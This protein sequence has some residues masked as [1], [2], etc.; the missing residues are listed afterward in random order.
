M[1]SVKPYLDNFTVKPAKIIYN[2]PS[3]HQSTTGEFY[4]YNGSGNNENLNKEQRKE[5]Y[6][7]PIC[8]Q[9]IAAFSESDLNQKEHVQ[10][11]SDENDQLV[12]RLKA[13]SSRLDKF[14]ATGSGSKIA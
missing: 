8:A 9:K 13:L 11:E 2:M 1:Y 10:P 4:D 6:F 12:K 7:E 14:I 3:Y 5:I